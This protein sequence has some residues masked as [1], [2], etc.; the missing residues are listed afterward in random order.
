[1]IG[2]LQTEIV[3]CLKNAISIARDLVAG[4]IETSSV[5]LGSGGWEGRTRNLVLVSPEIRVVVEI[6]PVGTEGEETPEQ[7][8]RMRSKREPQVTSVFGSA[9]EPHKNWNIAR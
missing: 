4:E 1:M 5:Y 7:W 2:C 6:G 8:F 9:V 3:I